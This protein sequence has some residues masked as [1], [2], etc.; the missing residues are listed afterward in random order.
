MKI[1]DVNLVKHTRQLCSKR[2]CIRKPN[3]I[4]SS[5]LEMYW[6]NEIKLAT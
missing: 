1:P 4:K 3:V 2:K 5:S 6:E